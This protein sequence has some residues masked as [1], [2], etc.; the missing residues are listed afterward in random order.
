MVNRVPAAAASGGKKKKITKFI[1]VQKSRP[2]EECR[3]SQKMA[4]GPSHLLIYKTHLHLFILTV[5]SSLTLVFQEGLHLNSRT[6]L[7]IAALA[8]PI[9]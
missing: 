1:T 5:T 4:R 9:W 2:L 7:G 6:T 8:L 3:L